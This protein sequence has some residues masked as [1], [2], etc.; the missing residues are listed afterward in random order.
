MKRAL[1]FV[2][3]GPACPFALLICVERSGFV[4]VGV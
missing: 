2:L 1:M 3:L 4:D